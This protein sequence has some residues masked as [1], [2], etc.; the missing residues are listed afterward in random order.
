MKI[1]TSNSK[2]F[3]LLFGFLVML[4]A[5]RWARKNA[6]EEP[7]GGPCSY[8]TTI[9][10]VRTLE[11]IGTE[12]IVAKFVIE[13]GEERITDADTLYLSDAIDSSL[14]LEQANRLGLKKDSL[15]TYEVMSIQSGSCNPHLEHFR[16]QRFDKTQTR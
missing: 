16:L 9:L 14:S 8:H 1:K 4:S 10:P 13:H 15:F 11:V 7:D 2:I 12:D 3:A 6:H 5:C